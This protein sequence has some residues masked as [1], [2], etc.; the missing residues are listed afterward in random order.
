MTDHLKEEELL[1][2]CAY[3]DGQ[4]NETV[5]QAVLAHLEVCPTCRALANTLMKTISLYRES[6]Q[7]VVLS[8]DARERLFSCLALEDLS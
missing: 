7:D 8:E 2:L 6:D 5:C 3:L 1:T 4:A